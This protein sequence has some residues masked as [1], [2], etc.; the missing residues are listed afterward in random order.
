MTT[1]FII[2]DKIIDTR[3]ISDRINDLEGCDKLDEEEQ[4]ELEG[5]KEFWEEGTAEF[6]H[7]ETLIREDYFEDYA[8]ELAE[9]IYGKELEGSSWPFTCIDWEK[10]A[11]ELKFD[12]TEA[13]L[14]G[15]TY[16]FRNC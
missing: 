12:Y 4:E 15:T 1:T 3:D 10:A 8:R 13:D 9:D 16:L 11:R 2:G 6:Q 14:N 7:G 5:L